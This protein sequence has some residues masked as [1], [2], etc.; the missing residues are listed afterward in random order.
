MVHFHYLDLLKLRESQ[1]RNITK[2]TRELRANPNAVT[3]TQL[4]MVTL[5][6]I[7]VFNKRRGGEM[8]KLL[9]STYEDK[10]KWHMSPDIMATLEPVEIKMTER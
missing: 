7:I 9:L 2:L 8:A 5:A 4:T 10:K 1:L 6:R 3:F